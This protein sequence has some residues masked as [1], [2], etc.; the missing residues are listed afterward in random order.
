LN[1]EP[2]EIET[3]V[4]VKYHLQSDSPRPERIRVSSEVA[5]GFLKH[6]VA[7][8]YPAEAKV[9]RIHGDVV[10]AALISEGGDVIR[11]KTISGDPLLADAATDAVKQWKYRPFKV[12]GKPIEMETK[13]IVKFR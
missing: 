3:T 4:I 10:L 7:P 5:E 2:I 9:H 8:V 11:L 12:D 13:V 6:K 1:G